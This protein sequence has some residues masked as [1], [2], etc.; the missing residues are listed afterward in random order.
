MGVKIWLYLYIID[1][2]DWETG[3]V[4]GW[5]DKDEADDFGMSWRTLQQQ[6][7]ELETDGYIACTQRSHSQDIV[8]H[9][10]INPR[11]YSGEIY[12]QNDK[13]TE[14][15][16]PTNDENINKNDEGT[17]QGTTEGTIKGL[18]KHSTPTSN[19][20][21]TYQESL[22]DNSRPRDPL[23]ENQAVK[24]YREVARVTANATQRE[25][26]AEKITDF[27]LWEE[28]LRHWLG[29]GW[30][31]YNVTGMIDSYKNGGGRTC[32]LCRKNGN[33]SKPAARP[34][35]AQPATDYEAMRSM[36][37]DGKEAQ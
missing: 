25:D 3:I 29:H 34:R 21:I 17:I 22:R 28:T 36:L 8:I 7:Q 35:P 6:R 30:S 14:N 5:K 18:S 33:G 9:N 2:A 1:R 10:W 12:N 32:N 19:S 15:S 26:I 16:V 11:E 31:K 20:H 24:T 23:L 4:Y 27:L 13:D 37:F